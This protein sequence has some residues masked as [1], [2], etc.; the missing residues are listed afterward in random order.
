MGVNKI[1]PGIKIME[2][3]IKPIIIVNLRYTKHTS[4]MAQMPNTMGSS[5]SVLDRPPPAAES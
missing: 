4:Q 3:N 2:L 1:K 5:E